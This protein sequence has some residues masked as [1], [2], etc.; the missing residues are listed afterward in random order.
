MKL[1]EVD[2]AADRMSKKIFLWPGIGCGQASMPCHLIPLPVYSMITNIFHESSYIVP[3]M[4][5]EGY[6]YSVI[7]WKWDSE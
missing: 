7:G 2:N 1:I 3:D 5:D 6:C 4:T